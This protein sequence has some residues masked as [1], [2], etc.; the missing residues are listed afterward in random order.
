MSSLPAIDWATAAAV[1]A[2]VAPAGA[3]IPRTQ[4]LRLVA[5]LRMAAER[6]RPAVAQATRLSPPPRIDVLVVDRPG[7][8]RSNTAS[9]RALLGPSTVA[10]LT[11]QSV[12]S[13][14]E[15]GAAL[16]A[17]STR[18]LGQFDAFAD[19]PVLLLIAPTIRAQADTMGVAADDFA[20]WVCLHEVVHAF[21]FHHA[22]WLADVI[23]GQ[24]RAIL[25]ADDQPWRPGRRLPRSVIDLVVG[26]AGG[27]ALAR[28]TTVMSLVEGHADVM[29]DATDAV[30]GVADLRRRFSG[31]RDSG[32]WAAVLR[33]V[34]GMDAKFA[35]YREGA[36]FCRAVI[37][38]VG[39]DGLNLAFRGP[40]DLPTPDELANPAAW[41]ARTRT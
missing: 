23:V 6:V 29:M 34:T 20:T 19:R 18:V 38:D 5:G 16:G 24:A 2:G 37:A 1:G 12:T 21:Q 27:D 4:A 17:L 8:V 26:P 13:G 11:P 31:R 32:G 7:W 41:V 14:A 10:P 3:P 22:P 15:L 9:V 25:S 28:L 30:P 36:A 40:D 35:Q 39:V 33:T